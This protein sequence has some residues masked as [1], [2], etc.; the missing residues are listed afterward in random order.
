MKRPYK[1]VMATGDWHTGHQVGLSTPEFHAPTIDEPKYLKLANVR[2]DIWEWF[3]EHL[4]PWLPI[5]ILLINGD[6]TDGKG[7]KSGGTEQLTADRKIQC[8]MAYRVIEFIDPTIIRMTYGTRYHVSSSGEDWEDLLA[9]KAGATIGSHEWYEVN[10]KI[11]DLKHKISGSQIPHGRYTPIAREMLW[12][13]EWSIDGSQPKADILL[14]SHCHYFSP[15][16]YD[17]SIGMTL[18]ALQ[19]FGSKYGAREC[20]GKVDIGFVIF[21]IYNN[22]EIQW[23]EVLA[24]TTTMQAKAEQL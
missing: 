6:A 20:S 16:K 10:G 14:R 21:D 9:D 12:N 23:Q 13:R 17:G 8:D 18:P 3:A 19:G 24:K 11:I 4:K 2:K 22:G 1:R 15:I 7:E 5:D